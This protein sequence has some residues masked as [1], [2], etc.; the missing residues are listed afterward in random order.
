MP[1]LLIS[2]RKY[3]KKSKISAVPTLMAYF[4]IW[5]IHP[6]RR[7]VQL[8]TSVYQ[9]FVALKSC[10][11]IQQLMEGSFFLHDC[12]THLYYC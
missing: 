7:N 9:D 3:V 10:K 11:V 8:A 6:I 1:G 2:P 5:N 12:A 4:L